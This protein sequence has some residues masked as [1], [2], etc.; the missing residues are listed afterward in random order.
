[1]P[2]YKV[3]PFVE[4]CLNSL[5]RQ[6]IPLSDY[7]IICIN[8]GS[9]DNSRQIILRLQAAYSNILL[10]DKQNEGVSRARNDGIE[11][12]TGKYVLFID[13]DDY[14]NHNC[15]KGILDKAD[16]LNA[17]I[18]FLG[19]SLVSEREF[20]EPNHIRIN[21]EGRIYTGIEAYFKARG[22]GLIDPDRMW[23]ILYNKPFLDENRLRFLADVPFLEDGEFIARILTQAER[24]I[25]DAT[26]F[27]LRTF[28][29]GSATNSDLLYSFRATRGFVIAA[30][31]LRQFQQ[32]ANLNKQQIEFLN[33][34]IIKFV[35]LA[36]C[37][38][39]H[40]H[41]LKRY[42]WI[43]REFYEN[44]L[45][46]CELNAVNET[47]KRYGKAYNTSPILLTL[48]CT[49]RDFIVRIKK[50]LPF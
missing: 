37:S 18:S 27:Y 28:R 41:C 21:D 7:E 10:I 43:K 23:G 25:F 6:D 38:C 32:N 22:N 19:F 11:I 30:I 34:P 26:S 14:I 46:K 39:K 9:P 12:A 31:N 35:T 2:I 17:Q 1:V 47:Y 33:Q 24:C 3:E 29:I 15:L 49:I 5:L 36:F 4:R 44:G 8:D 16:N 45:V 50:I 40:F 48:T 20:S 42:R 13:P